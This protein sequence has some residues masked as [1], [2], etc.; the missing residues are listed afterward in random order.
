MFFYVNY[1]EMIIAYY[2]LYR[3][4]A[5]ILFARFIILWGT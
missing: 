1:V 2:W 4:V 3:T 5:V